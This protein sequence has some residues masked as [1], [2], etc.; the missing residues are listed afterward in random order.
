MLLLSMNELTYKR[1]DRDVKTSKFLR[2][3]KTCC[4]TSCLHCPYGFTLEKEGLELEIIDESNFNEAR[5]IA[6]DSSPQTNDITASL[7]ASSFGG[8]K[9]NESLTQEN[10]DNYLIVKLKGETC[11]LVKKK[12]NR[13]IEIYHKEHFDDQ[14][15]TKE[16]VETFLS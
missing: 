6:P 11:A 16:M 12:N 15:I 9:K 2:N 7:L 8:N 4:K 5:Q 1:N 13:I 14:G 10:K 3:K